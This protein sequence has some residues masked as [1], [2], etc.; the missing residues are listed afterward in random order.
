ML[1]IIDATCKAR[2]VAATNRARAAEV[3]HAFWVLM[4]FFDARRRAGEVPGA[5]RQI[6]ENARRLCDLFESLEEMM[7]A[8]PLEL[9]MDT[10]LQIPPFKNWRTFVQWVARAF[11]WALQDVNS[12]EI[13]FS[14]DGPVVRL[15]MAALGVI[16]GD[17]AKLRPKSQGTL[18]QHLRAHL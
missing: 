10:G 5:D 18:A 1:N 2:G 6:G 14:D 16:A 13:G 3:H 12:R 17:D 9:E 4:R 7:L 8:T 15:T 11:Q